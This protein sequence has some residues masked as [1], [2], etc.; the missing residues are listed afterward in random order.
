MFIVAFFKFLLDGKFWDRHNEA[1]TPLANELQ[2][3]HDFV[4]QIPGENDH[5]V[6]LG[7]GDTILLID[8]NL[9][10]REEPPLLIR[11]AIDRVFNQV[12]A[13]ATVMQQRGALPWR[14]ISRDLLAFSRRAQ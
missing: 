8:R 7:L 2:L 6:G 14:A 5:V 10:A 4:F 12:G 13:D 11:T 3:A 1:S 9:I